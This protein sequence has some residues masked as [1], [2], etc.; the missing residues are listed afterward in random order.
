M[1]SKLEQMGHVLGPR[2]W[3]QVEFP[4]PVG[5]AIF[6]NRDLFPLSTTGDPRPAPPPEALHDFICFSL[7]PGVA[8]PHYRAMDITFHRKTL[9]TDVLTACM[10][11]YSGTRHIKYKFMEL[12]LGN[13]RYLVMLWPDSVATAPL[14]HMAHRLYILCRQPQCDLSPLFALADPIHFPQHAAAVARTYY[15]LLSPHLRP[16]SRWLPACDYVDCGKTV[17]AQPDYDARLARSALDILSDPEKLNILTRLVYSQT[18]DLRALGFKHGLWTLD[19]A[20]EPGDLWRQ[21]ED[22]AKR[23]DAWQAI[24]LLYYIARQPDAAVPHGQFTVAASAAL[25]YYAHM[26]PF[27]VL[28]AKDLLRLSIQ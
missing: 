13:R 23:R 6:E 20:A 5:D 24:E 4:G 3:A 7:M 15:M 9:S 2:G 22:A 18:R 1:A 26:I 10:T 28:L 14:G 19:P 21:A 17:F 12:R 11:Y 25:S 27:K 8:M 16:M